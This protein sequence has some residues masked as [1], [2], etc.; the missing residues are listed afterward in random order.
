MTFDAAAVA[1]VDEVHEVFNAIAAV[2]RNTVPWQPQE[3]KLDIVPV[4][5]LNVGVYTSQ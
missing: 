2:A 1:E 3:P 5:S 4:M